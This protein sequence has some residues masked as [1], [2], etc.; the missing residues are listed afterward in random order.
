MDPNPQIVIVH[1]LP[2]RLRLRLSHALREPERLLA[3]VTGH[4]GL[5]SIVYTHITRSVLAQFDPVRLPEE[6]ILLR[7]ALALGLDAGAVPVRVTGAGGGDRM[8]SSAWVAGALL[9]AAAGM[10]I[11]RRPES[12]R[13]RWEWLAAMSTVGA[14]LHHGW[15]ELD[16]RGYFDPE[17]LTLAYLASAFLRGN[18]LRAAAVTWG[19]TFG[20]H[21]LQE[22]GQGIVVRPVM[23][24]GRDGDP[25]RY[26]IAVSPETG[27]ASGRQRIVTL[28]RAL[29]GYIM[30]G[31]GGRDLLGDMRRVSHVHGEVLEGMGWMPDGIPLRFGEGKWPR[32]GQ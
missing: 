30:A 27:A 24:G 32:R 12:Q 20:R 10:R 9:L 13:A 29:L 22:R 17:V 5:D 11:V 1:R 26:E 25:D 19:A 31:A 6:E 7:V 4:E 18:L 8:T 21:L 2:G 23:T 28:L 14:V 3:T 15:Q 16:E